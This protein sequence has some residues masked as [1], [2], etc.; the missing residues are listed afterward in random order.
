L[1]EKYTSNTDL[2]EWTINLRPGVKFSDGTAM[3]AKDVVATFGAQWDVKNPLHVGNT[4]NFD[5]WTYLF[6]AFLNAPP[7]TN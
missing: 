2:T 5:Y 7:P 4:G 6:T 1:A 3:T